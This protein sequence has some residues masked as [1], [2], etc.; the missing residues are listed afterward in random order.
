M[1]NNDAFTRPE[2][3][4]SNF[5]DSIARYFALVTLF[6]AFT[7]GIYWAI[8]GD[9]VRAWTS[10]TAVLIVACPCVLSLSTPFTLSS[11]LSIF[12]KHLFYLKSPNIVEQLAKVDTLVFDKTGTITSPDTAEVNFSADLS[13]V[14]KLLAASLARNSGH[15]LSQKIVQKIRTGIYL[16]VLDFKE[17]PGKGISGIINGNLVKLGSPTDPRKN[18][19]SAGSAASHLEIHGIYKGYFEIGQYWRSGLRTLF[20][21][22]APRYGLHLISGDN[23]A[24]KEKLSMIMP[25]GSQLHFRQSP[26]SKLNYIKE[27]QLKG[28]NVMMLGDGLN[29]AGALQQSDVGIAV[30]DNINTFSPACDAIL[31]GKSIDR[32]PVFI[33]QAQD[34]LKTIRISFIISGTYNIIGVYFAVQ[35]LLSPLLA[36]VLMPLSTISVIL[37]TS[38]ATRYY[39]A[40]N[41]LS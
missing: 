1:W 14:D 19:S 30:T 25:H 38:A 10:F 5:N 15:P 23:E 18:P 22:L 20:Q 31:N 41:K 4:P 12:D 35:G 2:K 33:R 34:A 6:I 26:L 7:A 8:S 36:A 16:P 29:D 39:A 13:D 17:I 28:K 32:I 24:D 11:V 9:T 37:F 40:K 27:L 21:D 3:A